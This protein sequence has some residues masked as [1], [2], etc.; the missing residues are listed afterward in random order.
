MATL[1]SAPPLARTATLGRSHPLATRAWRALL[2]GVMAL[3]V[4]N[5]ALM[6][7]AVATNSFARRWL[8]TWLP[9]GWT[10]TWYLDAWKEFQLASILWVTVEVVFAVVILALADLNDEQLAAIKADPM[11]ATKEIV[12]EMLTGTLAG[13][14]DDQGNITALEDMPEEQLRKI[15]AD[16]EIPDA[17]TLPVAD[18]VAA[19]QAEQVKVPAAASAAATS[20]STS[21]TAK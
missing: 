4:V 12:P 2:A 15:G 14:A 7:A 3:F 20:A 19:I 16:M 18:L 6:I 1:S 17:D 11:L 13:V 8:G 10:T 5:V 21:A 9:Q